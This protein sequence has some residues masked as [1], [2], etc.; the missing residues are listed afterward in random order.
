MVLDD[1]GL[2]IVVSI[3]EDPETHVP[4]V[5]E[6]E[7]RLHVEAA[8]GAAVVFSLVGKYTRQS[9]RTHPPDHLR[10]WYGRATSAATR[11]IVNERRD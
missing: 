2:D 1:V 7:V 8:G 3:E 4:Q 9:K 6:V 5:N 11:R 10:L